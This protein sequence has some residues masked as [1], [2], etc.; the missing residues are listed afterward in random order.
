M[1][2]GCGSDTPAGETARGQVVN[3]YNWSDYVAPDT[4]ANFERE[5]GIDVN[6]DVYDSSEIV[7]AKLL[8]GGS[9]YDVVFHSYQFA[10]RLAPLGIF[11]E[12]DYS[13]LDNFRHLN[14][15]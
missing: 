7:D 15:E 3:I 14:R 1:L 13:K 6:Y 11:Q 12:L 8:A 5:Y 10:S 9:G 2:A 4:I